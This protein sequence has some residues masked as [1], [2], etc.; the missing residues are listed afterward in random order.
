MRQQQRPRI[1]RRWF[2]IGGIILVL[3]ISISSIV[4]F[5]TDVLWFDELGFTT[6][7]WKI[8]WTRI[9][10]G[11]VGGAIAAIVVFANLE[12]ARRAAPRHRFVAA[13]GG[14]ITEQY[15]T[16]FRP[17]ARLASI[18]VAA[19]VG[20]FTGLSTS[21][22]WERYLL[23]RNARPFGVRAPEPFGQDVSFYVFSIPFQRAILSLLFGV[24]V[25]SLLLAAVAHLFNGS[26]QPETNRVRIGTVVKVHLSVLLGLI[27]LLKAWAYRLDVFELVF[28]GRGAVTLASNTDVHSQRPAL[29]VL[30]YIA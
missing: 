23:W 3:F 24:L 9:G 29:K 11:V 13:G 2:V 1:Q 14:D 19:V 16:A 28:S 10:V 20:L 27:A 5:Y 4:R 21:G 26:I 7:F 12:V 17:Y 25:V 22:A 30:F 15:R 8:L 6:V 18:V